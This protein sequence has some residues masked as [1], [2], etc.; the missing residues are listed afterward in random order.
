MPV[1]LVSSLLLACVAGSPEPVVPDTSRPDRSDVLTACG[2]APGESIPSVWSWWDEYEPWGEPT[3]WTGLAE[4]DRPL[5]E[6]CA[7]V[8]GDSVG[9]DWDSFG[10]EPSGFD[11]PTT[12]GHLVVAGLLQLAAGDFG[13]LGDLRSSL[14]P[15]ELLAIDD[16]EG[17]ATDP[18]AEALFAYVQAH[19]TSVAWQPD[20]LSCAL[21]YDD[22]RVYVCLDELAFTTSDWWNTA[23]FPPV[24]AAGFVHEAGHDDGPLH[25]DGE[26]ADCNGTYGATAR[27]LDAWITWSAPVAR[28]LDVETVAYGLE[29]T[30]SHIGTYDAACP[31]D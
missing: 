14:S 30:C 25:V 31:C 1:S 5:T 20:S 29:A 11:T 4:M 27:V 15:T 18:A 13:S 12:T 16:L 17:D 10:E 9:L 23:G 26:D 8:L 21:W 22:G 28:P 24:L 7:A 19:V 3:T 6:E 2:L